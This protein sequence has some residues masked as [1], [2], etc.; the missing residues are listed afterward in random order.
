MKT[1]LKSKAFISIV[2]IFSVLVLAAGIFL[3]TVGV[4]YNDR[5]T[6]VVV[7]PGLLCSSLE[8]DET[9]EIFY[10][11]LETDTHG[12]SFDDFGS[13]K[14][15]SLVVDIAL[16]TKI[17]QK[18]GDV[19][20][21]VPGNFLDKFELDETGAPIYSS[22]A[23]QWDHDG[24]AKYGAMT[25]M[26]TPYEYYANLYSNK[27]NYDTFIFQYDWR[28]DNRIA[29]DQLI[30]ACKDYDDV[31][32]VAHSMG[33]IVSSLAIAKNETFRKKVILNCSYASPYLGSFN[34]LRI[35]E[36]GE[37]TVGSLLGAAHDALDNNKV[38]NALFGSI[39]EKADNICY[40]KVLPIFRKMPGIVQLLPTIDLVCPDG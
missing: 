8:E 7:I 37:E 31:I 38:L 10:D 5:K 34:A 27:K 4:M 32:I 40:E 22:K 36:N 20:D 17:V 2:V 25:M 1:I 9:G 39:L 3:T 19:L 26:K 30:E 35:L 23:V 18:V 28:R 13:N 21:E 33:N 11:P 12:F 29:A 6:A 24:Y 15:I 14:M 16:H